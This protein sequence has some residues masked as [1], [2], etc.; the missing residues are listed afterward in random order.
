MAFEAGAAGAEAGATEAGAAKGAADVAAADTAGAAAVDAGAA[1]TVADTGAAT[2]A[3][4]TTATALTASDATTAGLTLK[5]GLAAAQGVG[6][7]GGLLVAEQGIQ[8]AKDLAADAK[9]AAAKANA[10]ALAHKPAPT[11]DPDLAE[12]RK[13]NALLFG[14]EDTDIT[15]GKAP[16]G[17]LG[18]TTLLGGTSSLGG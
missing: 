2:L 3:A 11:I 16:V 7:V 18:R 8:N 14:L 15:K 1:A 12:I 4:D 13:K 10:D 17:D 5:D 9:T 6:A